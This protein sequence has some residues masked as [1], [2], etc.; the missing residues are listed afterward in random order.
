[1]FDPYKALYLHIPFCKQRC[2]YCDFATSAASADDPE[3]TRYVEQLVLDIRRA[4]REE[5][6]GS[7]ETVYIG[8]GTP[9][10]IGMKNLSALLYALSTSMHLTP[11]VECTMEANPESLTEAMVKDLWALGVN[12]LSIGVQSFDNALLEK[13]GRVHNAQTAK[14]AIACAQTRFEN[15]SIDLMCGLPGQTPEDFERDLVSAVEAGVSHVSVYPLT[16]E[17]NTPLERLVEA[18]M[19]E[20]PLEDMQ[21]VMME[22]A[23]RVLGPAGFTRYEVASYAK[24]GYACRHNIAYWTG[25]PYLGIGTSAVTMTQNDARRM[26]VQDGQVVDDLDRKQMCAEYLMLKMRM[27][28]GVRDEEVREA[29]L[30][31]PEALLA[32]RGLVDAGLAE[33]TEGAYRPTTVGWLCGNELYGRLFDLA[34]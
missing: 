26:R 3:I 5:K 7:I 30:V 27:V 21:A 4:S 9:S 22:A 32:F 25:K 33:H 28:E 2:A 16:V 18:G 24:P 17:E 20:E 31:L 1:M 6:L 8:G 10:H 19:L 29:S 13:L 11:E 34:P 15:V 23:L 14:R 12:R